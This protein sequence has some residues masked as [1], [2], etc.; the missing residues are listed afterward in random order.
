MRDAIL[1]LIVGGA[2]PFIVWRPPIGILM[3]SWL[4]YMNPHRL[5]WGFAYTFPFSQL[6][7]LATLFGLL[8]YKD[9]R[10]VP[11]TP[12]TVL[13]MLFVIW[14][15]ISTV[16]S[17]YPDDAW[18]EWD[19][20]VKI[21]LFTFLTIILMQQE[22][23]TRILVWVIALSL[24]FYGVK[25]GIFSIVTAGNYRV[26]G[27]QGSFIEDNNALALACMM[28]VPLMRFCQL[29]AR[30]KLVRY[31]WLGVIG[32]TGI[33]ILTS[34][35]RGALVGVVATLAFAWWKSR[36]KLLGV[37][38][39]LPL[40]PLVFSFMPEHWFERMET[41]TEY[42]QDDS[43]MGR[44][45]A[46]WFAFN[47]ALD[48]PFFGGGFGVFNPELFF[49]YAPE[50]DRFH[51]S[52]SI[53]FE[54]LAEHGF[55]GLAM[56][57][58]IGV[59]ALREAGKLSRRQ[60]D[61]DRAWI[62]QLAGLLQISF[63]SYATTGAFLGLAYFDLYYQLVAIL[64]VLKVLASRGAEPLSATASRRQVTGKP[65]SRTEP[66]EGD[67]VPKAGTQGPYGRSR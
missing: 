51:D 41:I 20:T 38:L 65:G 37:L 10:A 53:Y 57:L 52:H 67:T 22:R 62:A 13:L 3:W 1:F 17:V 56:F 60:F 42:E 5:T 6:T 31:A 36:H 25:G 47:V 44:I 66:P 28:T 54:V 40:V 45:N 9:R 8:F 55:F 18:Q 16:L 64:V 27:P 30:H 46:W 24:G 12:L 11:L 4:G 14:M 43:A 26:W 23:N 15:T 34:H 33:S 48:K 2:L 29:Q 19:R 7:A 39:V 21:Q 59:L 61:K 58:T 63:V 50:P 49:R 35:S 32:L